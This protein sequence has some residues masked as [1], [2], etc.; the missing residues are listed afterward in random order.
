MSLAE[1]NWINAL[2][3]AGA[4]TTLHLDQ[5][6][7]RGL[8]TGPLD[9][10]LILRG[11]RA[12]ALMQARVSDGALSLAPDLDCTATVPLLTLG[13]HGLILRD[14]ALTD[15]LADKLLSRLSPI[16]KDSVNTR[17]R[18]S[19]SSTEFNLPLTEHA[20]EKADMGALLNFT[21]VSFQPSRLYRTILQLMLDEDVRLELP[22][23]HVFLDFRDGK[24]VQSPMRIKA[25]EYTITT[26]GAIGL[27]ETLDYTIEMPVTSKS[28]HAPKDG[29]IRI[30][31]TGTLDHPNILQGLLGAGG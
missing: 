28:P 21:G 3:I 24:L 8:R 23:Q 6:A 14:V 10:P 25:G 13:T 7:Y 16:F 5:L 27:D 11:G 22:D 17:G 19:L 15:E 26:S 31:L 9:I 18:F 4:Q 20:L 2:R 12:S 30:R 29:V 1:E